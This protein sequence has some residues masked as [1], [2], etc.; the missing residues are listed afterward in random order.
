MSAGNPYLPLDLIC[1]GIGLVIIGRRLGPLFLLVTL[2]ALL[3]DLEYNYLPPKGWGLQ[4]QHPVLG[5]GAL[6]YG[7]MMTAITVGTTPITGYLKDRKISQRADIGIPVVQKTSPTRQRGK[8]SNKE[9]IQPR[10][11]LRQ[12]QATLQSFKESTNLTHEALVYKSITQ[13]FNLRILQQD[14]DDH[15][16]A[17]I[18]VSRTSYLSDGCSTKCR[19]I[20]HNSG[21]LT[22]A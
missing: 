13:E 18:L 7:C 2:P 3:A 6:F 19:T 8:E 21:A 9:V 20:T 14:F 15:K 16:A 22:R 5:V 12:M 17:F 4:V 10:E 11:Q 1:V